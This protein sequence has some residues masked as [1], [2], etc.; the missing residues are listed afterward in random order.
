MPFPTLHFAT[1]PSL[2]LHLCDTCD[3]KKSKTRLE[4]AR[5]RTCLTFNRFYL[6]AYLYTSLITKK[7]PHEIPSICNTKYHSIRLLQKKMHF[8]EF[9]RLFC[10]LSPI[11]CIELLIYQRHQTFWTPTRENNPF[12]D[13]ND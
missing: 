12:Y 6:Q 10:A 8:S 2:F 7:L 4:R 11:I 1:Y 5:I 3:S 13:F 9:L